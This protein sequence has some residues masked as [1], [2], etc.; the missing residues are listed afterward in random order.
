MRWN[1]EN[2][3]ARKMTQK[4]HRAKIRHQMDR[5]RAGHVDFENLPFDRKRGTQGWIST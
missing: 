2:K 5:L 3:W 4:R 1:K